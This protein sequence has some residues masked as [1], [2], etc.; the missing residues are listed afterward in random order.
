M[1]GYEYVLR[2]GNANR[3]AILF[4]ALSYHHKFLQFL[5]NRL[6]SLHTE[7]PTNTLTGM[8]SCNVV[9]KQGY[10]LSYLDIV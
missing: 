8:D 5:P 1:V 10:P 4:L 7:S 2:L 9:H 6:L 3:C